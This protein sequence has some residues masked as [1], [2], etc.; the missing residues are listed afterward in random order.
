MNKQ[1]IKTLIIATL[2]INLSSCA[3][4]IKDTTNIINKEQY[5]KISKEV[6]RYEYN[7]M[8]QLKV[9]SNLCTYEVYIND[10]LVDF[11]FTTGRTAGEQNI[12]IPQ[13]ILKSGVQS[14]CFKVYPKAVKTETLE[15][16]VDKNAEFSIRI[17]H[18][19]YYKTK[20]ENFVEDYNIKLPK[21][22]KETPSVEFKGEFKATVPYV[23]EGWSKGVD[24]RKEDQKKLEAEVVEKCNQFRIAFSTKDIT[25]IATMIYNREREIAQA[26]FFDSES[27]NSYNN[28]WKELEEK[29]NALIEMKPINNYSMKIYG[30]GKI[31]CL[32]RNEGKLKDFPVVYGTT[33]EKLRFYGL[34]FY[35]PKPGA[36][37]EVIR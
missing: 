1:L 12:D 28:G 34:F 30:D 5:N 2:L 24:L 10:M 18:G 29:C 16:L 4:K 11:S 19:E 23:L 17:V 20:F 33:G 21:I 25:T 8:Y 3:Q 9:N 7:P 14:V 6:K 27:S 32:L 36:P 15:T 37:L 13:Y 31:T 26:F 22:E 35:R